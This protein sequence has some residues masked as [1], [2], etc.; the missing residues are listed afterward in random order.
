MRK[1]IT[2]FVL[3]LVFSLLSGSVF[4]G[5]KGVCDENE[6]GGKKALQ[7]AGVYGLCVA[8][9]NA[10]DA[11]KPGI[12]EKFKAR[13]GDDVPGLDPV[14]DFSCPCFDRVSFADVCTYGAPIY[15]PTVIDGVL[16]GGLVFFSLENGESVFFDTF[17]ANCSYAHVDAEFNAIDEEYRSVEQGN[18][19]VDDEPFAC[20]ADLEAIGTITADDCAAMGY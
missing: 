6:Y 3:I 1:F 19:L 15:M 12:A 17:D 5:D 14:L 16:Q 9:Q 11:D 7:K 20:R 8:Y 2:S 13:F 18:P 4:A 10:D